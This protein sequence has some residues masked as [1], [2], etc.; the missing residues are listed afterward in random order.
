MALDAVPQIHLVRDAHRPADVDD[1]RDV[2]SAAE[3]PRAGVR[4][5]GVSHH[6]DGTPADGGDGAAQMLRAEKSRRD[7]LLSH[8]WR[9]RLR[10]DEPL[11]DHPRRR[12]DQRNRLTETFAHLVDQAVPAPPAARDRLSPLELRSIVFGLMTAMLLAA[13]DQ[14]IVA[15]AMPTIGLDLGDALAMALLLRKGFKEEDFAFLHP[16]GKLGK[17]FLRVRDLTHVY[18]S[19]HSRVPMS[20]QKGDLV[21][22]AR[23]VRVMPTL[24][25]TRWS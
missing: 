7:R 9:R 10:C 21:D 3:G 20:E 25:V 1:E 6:G 2:R 16:G 11:R 4:E 5:A 17:R 8:A 24:V 19:C 23:I 15:T 12:S 22:G 18:R 14:T 13:L